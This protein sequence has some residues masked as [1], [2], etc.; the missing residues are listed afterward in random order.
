MVRLYLDLETYRPK[1][2][3]E[4]AKSKREQLVNKVMGR[5]CIKVEELSS[6]ILPR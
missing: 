4:L 6:S 3:R 2:E 1:K 5:S